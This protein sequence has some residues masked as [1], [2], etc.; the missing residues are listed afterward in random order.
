MPKVTGNKKQ[1]TETNNGVPY[2]LLGVRRLVMY[3][4]RWL[5][6][7]KFRNLSR[8]RFKTASGINPVMHCLDEQGNRTK[9][10]RYG[11]KTRARYC[12]VR[13]SYR[14]QHFV[15]SST[16]VSLSSFCWNAAARAISC[17]FSRALKFSCS[18]SLGKC[19]EML[20]SHA[21]R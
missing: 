13:L 17:F 16:G 21:R 5:L 12:E 6:V 3:D 4:L 18:R 10:T 14:E 8:E 11:T 20:A 9:K 15:K 7:G 2:L 1:E 19:K